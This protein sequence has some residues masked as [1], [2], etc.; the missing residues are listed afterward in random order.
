MPRTVKI[1][2]IA[3]FL[4]L[5]TV[6]IVMLD[7]VVIYKRPVVGPVEMNAVTVRMTPTPSPGDMFIILPIKN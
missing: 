1:G 6:N 4:L 2:L 3:S 7:L 5:L